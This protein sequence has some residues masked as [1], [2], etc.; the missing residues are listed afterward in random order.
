[1]ILE[2][3]ATSDWHLCGLDK[4]FHDAVT[5]QLHEVDKIYQYAVANGV[6]HV[7]VPGDIS[8]TPHMP[9][10]VY[11]ALVLFLK[12]YDGIINTH[13][14]LGNHDFSD[15]RK[16]SM[17]LLH[18][19]CEQGMFESFHMH[20]KMERMKIDGCR[21]NFLPYPCLEAP[22]G[23]PSLNFTHVEYNGAVGD[24]GRKLR[25]K[26]EFVQRESDFNVSGHI[27][28]YQV[29]KKQCAVYCG[30]PYQKNFGERLPKGFIHFKARSSGRRVEF[31]HKFVDNK[32]D[33]QLVNAVVKS[34][35][36]LGRLSSSDA[37]RYKLWMSPEVEMP[38]DLRLRFPNITGGIFDLESKEKKVE[39]AVAAAQTQQR[40]SVN[41]MSGLPGFLRKAG[42]KK[43]SIREAKDIVR[44]AANEL[45]IQMNLG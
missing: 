23:K 21:V 27:H 14:I 9:Y 35:E 5:R 36:D 37:I 18:V 43:R 13:Y 1:M 26:D 17:D 11:I 24:N 19:L 6:Q 7:F 20:M 28:Q 25:V 45:G 33:F 40:R 16:T 3:I 29:L 31:K 30:N 15:T 34:R 12:K 44:Q 4:H 10:D 2:G 38:K 39:E 22:H 41:I 32:P 8:D 42:F